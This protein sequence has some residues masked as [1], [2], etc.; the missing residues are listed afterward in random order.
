MSAPDTEAVRPELAT[1]GLLCRGCGKL[2]ADNRRSCVS[3]LCR[4]LLGAKGTGCVFSL[5]RLWMFGDECE[6][7][8][9]SPRRRLL[10]VDPLGP[11]LLEL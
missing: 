4:A 1:V 10:G 3:R 9:S 5:T 6:Y 8:N 2:A 11:S 7:D